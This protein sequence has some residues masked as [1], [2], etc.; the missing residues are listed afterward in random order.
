MVVAPLAGQLSDRINGK[1]ILL[2]GCGISALGT[3]LVAGVL[4]LDDTPWSF[5]VPL[6]IGGFGLG[7]TMVPLMAVAMREVSPAMSGV[8][9]GFMNTVRQVGAAMGTAVV[10]AVLANQVATELP[11]QAGR[12][13]AQLPP[14]ACAQFLAHWQAASHS[15]QQ[16]GAGQTMS[17]QPPPG[18]SPEVARHIGA[19]YQQTFATAF[20]NGA[21]PALTVVVIAMG[22]GAVIVLWLRGGRTAEEARQTHEVETLAAAS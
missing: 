12:L 10:G 22:I 8:A 5:T 18:V 21:R 2:V 1:Y 13:A 16:F 17:F 19:V 14:Q 4:A 11:R 6:A 3:G 20:L 7:C 9:S 15:A